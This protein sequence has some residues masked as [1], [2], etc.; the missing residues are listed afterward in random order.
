MYGTTGRPA[1]NNNNN[2]DDDHH[3]VSSSDS[4]ST[5]FL[6][7]PFQAF[8]PSLFVSLQSPDD[9]TTTTTNKT[10]TT[11]NNTNH[12]TAT[13]HHNNDTLPSLQDRSWIGARMSPIL[14]DND[15]DNDDNNNDNHHAN[16]AHQQ[17]QN[18]LFMQDDYYYSRLQ[19]PSSSQQQP[20]HHH[21]HTMP[22]HHHHH[23][24]HT[25]RNQLLPSSSHPVWMM[26]HHNQNHQVPP[27]PSA[28][29]QRHEYPAF[30]IH[31]LQ[32][33]ES[34]RMMQEQLERTHQRHTF[35]R[36]GG[37]LL[38]LV[39]GLFL[40]GMGIYDAYG[41]YLGG[42]GTN[43]NNNNNNN[44]AW[45]LP[46][47]QPGP[48][49]SVL[50]GGLTPSMLLLDDSNRASGTTTSWATLASYLTSYGRLVS[51]A[52]Q[53]NSVV[54]W[55][56]VALAWFV[57]QRPSVHQITRTTLGSV[58]WISVLTG[59]LWMLAVWWLLAS[60]SQP[61]INHNN[62]SNAVLVAHCAAW[63]TGG[64]LCFVGMVRPQ[65]R[66][67]CFMICIG[68]VV[69][70]LLQALWILPGGTAVTSRSNAD[71]NN[72]NYY[73]AEE[74]TSAS[75]SAS[76]PLPLVVGCAASSFVGWALYGSQMIGVVTTNYSH[77]PAL[78]GDQRLEP[79]SS[80]GMPT[81]STTAVTATHHLQ[82]IQRG[83][84][85]HSGVRF[86]C[87]MVVVMAWI[88]PLLV[89]AYFDYYYFYYGEGR[90]SSATTY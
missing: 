7:H 40:V 64:V 80:M 18:Q 29:H 71:N 69:L 57:C 81:T 38:C 39:S 28:G 12:N 83:R 70:S 88:M 58:Y 33:Q 34:R 76:N 13:D 22:L 82:R 36:S 42:G 9:P 16:N 61:Y 89:L 63:G 2:N 21:C 66:F 77:L 25:T 3:T 53:S 15:D 24:H 43:N 72:N 32:S 47:G 20:P 51:S 45:S 75:G 27:P 50:W 79:L 26:N 73:S 19:P 65:R 55:L 74:Q 67:G 78:S 86:F 35:W 48:A 41:S 87:A 23:P 1:Y 31:P 49:T 44:H 11:A 62:N 8:R 85:V 68:L 60:P 37:P 46:W 90:A 5:D 59:Q 84:Q 4:S 10:T 14:N 6:A 30:G 56:L 17:Q 52:V 54:E